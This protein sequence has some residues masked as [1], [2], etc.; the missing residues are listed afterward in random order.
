MTT[1]SIREARGR[2]GEL[3]DQ[4]QPGEEMEIKNAIFACPTHLGE[5]LIV[6]VTGGPLCATTVQPTSYMSHML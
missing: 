5:E 1:I 6:A 4:L 3:V 2:L